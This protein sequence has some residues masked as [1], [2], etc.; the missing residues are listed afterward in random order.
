MTAWFKV[1][2]SL[3][4]NSSHKPR[5]GKRKWT[6]SNRKMR[7]NLRNYR[8]NTT[9]IKRTKIPPSAKSYLKKYLS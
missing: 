2:K 1:N 5:C 7:R 4:P 6:I 8:I 3:N 9:K